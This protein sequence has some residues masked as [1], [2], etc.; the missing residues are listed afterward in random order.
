VVSTA[1]VVWMAYKYMD[2]PYIVKDAIKKERTGPLSAA[3]F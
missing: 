3:V 2:A 1:G